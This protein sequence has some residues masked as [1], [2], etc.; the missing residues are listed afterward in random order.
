LSRLSL[1]ET[2]AR[3]RKAFATVV[4]EYV[5]EPRTYYYSTFAP[6]HHRGVRIHVLWY[7]R[8]GSDVPNT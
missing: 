4:Y 3:A 5:D 6:K 1:V 2:V 8:E 7:E